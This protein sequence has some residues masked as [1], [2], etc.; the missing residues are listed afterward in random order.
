M[1]EN[2]P[3]HGLHKYALGDTDW[4]HSPDMQTIEERLVIRDVEENLQNYTAHAAATF[5][6]TDTGAVYDGT[7]SSWESA[8]RGFDTV[9]TNSV[10]TA[11]VTAT[12][13]ITYPDGSVVTSPPG[14]SNGH[15]GIIRGYN[16]TSGP[17]ADAEVN[18]NDYADASK[19]I[20]DVVDSLE[21]E[22]S[23]REQGVVRIPHVDP[24]GEELT[25]ASTVTFG[26]NGDTYP[27][28][29]GSTGRNGPYIQVTIDD[30]SPA[31]DVLGQRLNGIH[32]WGAFANG[33]GNDCEFIRFY[34]TNACTY[35]GGDLRAFCGPAG[36]S[37]RGTILIDSKCWNGRI[38]NVNF[39]GIPQ[40]GS[41][42]DVSGMSCVRFLDSDGGSFSGPGE[43]LIQ[44]LTTYSAPSYPMN[45]II[46]SEINASNLRINNC[47]FESAGGKGL[48]YLTKGGAVITGNQLGRTENSASRI[49]HTGFDVLIG[50]NTH[51][52]SAE[53]GYYIRAQQGR[54]MNTTRYSKV[55]S[56]AIDVG[57]PG[58]SNGKLVV[59]K[60]E[61][62][63]GPVNYP[64]NASNVYFPDG[65]QP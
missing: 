28:F 33:N 4:T 20:Q 35:Y 31:F 34:H 12:E 45:N 25:I 30:G 13:S 60:P 59:P 6:S 57:D 2:T 64:S 36:G 29:H 42:T 44:G 39:N 43:W 16:G 3:N 19:A 54:I 32:I 50:P 63:I 46:H 18:P 62:I 15:D 49:H 40:S 7:G 8:S 21:S 55:S 61:T 24:N 51:S 52:A 17:G 23:G 47:R 9:A 11:Q 65:S 26:A 58:G 41:K 56:F 38:Q 48:I 37:A 53:N 27:S 10:E 1:V 5:V 14:S 22:Q